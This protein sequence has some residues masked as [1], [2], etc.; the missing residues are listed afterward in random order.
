MAENVLSDAANDLKNFRLG[1]RWSYALEVAEVGHRPYAWIHSAPAKSTIVLVHALGMSP[2]QTRDVARVLHSNGYNVIAPLLDGHGVS[3]VWFEKFLN[4][5]IETASLWDNTLSESVA[6][7]REQGGSVY[8]MGFSIGGTH[9]LDWA[10][11]HQTL[12]DGLILQSPT[13]EVGRVFER[14]SQSYPAKKA[15]WI[16]DNFNDLDSGKL[17]ALDNPF[18]CAFTPLGQPTSARP[19]LNNYGYVDTLTSSFAFS[20]AIPKNARKSVHEHSFGLPTFVVYSL[21]DKVMKAEPIVEFAAIRSSVSTK[22]YQKAERI[23]HDDTLWG[24]QSERMARDAVEWIES[25]K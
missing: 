10:A 17:N 25:R 9:S 14:V 5:P 3:R 21:H 2:G 19:E 4:Q 22:V 11:R 24:P 1:P 12:V 23:S 18:F 16:A 20:K 8:L 7:A 15:K 6:M 13:F